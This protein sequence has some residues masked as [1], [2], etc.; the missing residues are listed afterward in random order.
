MNLEVNHSPE[1]ILEYFK[2]LKE[3]HKD[4]FNIDT[5]SE[6]VQMNEDLVLLREDLNKVRSLITD[7][8]DSTKSI[9]NE[10]DDINKK[11]YPLRKKYLN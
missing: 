8:S 1:I 3:W 6:V 4:K 11:F 5:S 9:N 10:I 7:E 2:T